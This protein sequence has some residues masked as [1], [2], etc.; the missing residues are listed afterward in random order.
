MSRSGGTHLNWL[1]SPAVDEG[2]GKVVTGQQTTESENDV[3]DRDIVES[4]I[5]GGRWIV[6]IGSARPETDSL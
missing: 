3:S 2:K 4:L 5:E 6:G 1:P